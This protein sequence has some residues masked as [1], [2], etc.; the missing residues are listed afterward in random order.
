MIC[1]I[2]KRFKNFTNKRVE[3]FQKMQLFPTSISFQK[4]KRTWG[5]V[6]SKWIEFQYFTYEISIEVMDYVI[7]HELAH[8]KT[9]ESF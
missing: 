4:N 2:K 5:L 6:I 3:N 9:Q 7:V 8:I 1:F